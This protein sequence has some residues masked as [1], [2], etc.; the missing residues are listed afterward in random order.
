MRRRIRFATGATNLISVCVV[1]IHTRDVGRIE[2]DQL[3][4][5]VHHVARIAAR[6]QTGK[7]IILKGA[8]DVGADAQP[9]SGRLHVV[10]LPLA[11]FAQ[12]GAE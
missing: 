9:T 2:T 3:R 8:E 12:Y 11:R 5:C 6:G 7:I 4:I 10:A 1:E